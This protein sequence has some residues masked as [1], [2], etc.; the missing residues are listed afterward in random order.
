MALSALDDKSRTPND[1]QLAEVLGESKRS[2][3]EIAGYRAEAC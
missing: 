3:D 1:A 2:W